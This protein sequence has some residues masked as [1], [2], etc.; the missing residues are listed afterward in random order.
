MI[1]CRRSMFRLMEEPGNMG[2]GGMAIGIGWEL[3]C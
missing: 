1:V 2:G 3:D